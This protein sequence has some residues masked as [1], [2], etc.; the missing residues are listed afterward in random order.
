MVGAPGGR[1][2]G[3]KGALPRLARLTE[4]ISG[5]LDDYTMVRAGLMRQTFNR[6]SSTACWRALPESATRP[7]IAVLCAF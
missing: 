2:G 4:A 1:E 5:V 7:T 6:D 3:R